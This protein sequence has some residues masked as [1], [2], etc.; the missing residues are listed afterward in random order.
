MYVSICYK[1]RRGRSYNIYRINVSLYREEVNREGEK[2][3]HTRDDKKYN[4]GK[5]DSV[6]ASYEVEVILNTDRVQDDRSWY[7]N[8]I[9]RIGNHAFTSKVN[10]VKIA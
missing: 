4:N 9:T 3:Q 10:K 8:V 6:T 1:G 5:K 7:E 2:I